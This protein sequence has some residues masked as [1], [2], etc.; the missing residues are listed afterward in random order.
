MENVIVVCSDSLK[1]TPPLTLSSD[2]ATALQSLRHSVLE[3]SIV[4]MTDA[5]GL[6]TF[7]NGNFEKISGYTKQ[8]VL[9]KSHSLL[10]SK[11]HPPKFWSDMWTHI[12]S[13]K[14]WSDEVCNRAKNGSLYWVRSSITPS[15]DQSGKIIGYISIRYDITKEKKLQEDLRQE[16]RLQSIMMQTA[17]VGIF[18]T[19]S[20]GNCLYVNNR[21]AEMTGRPAEESLGA[22]WIA[23]FHAEDK[24]KVFNAWADFVTGQSTF[25]LRWRLSRPDGGIRWVQ[26]T[27]DCVR[28]DEGLVSSYIATAVDI[29]ELINAQH[30]LELKQSETNNINRS[31]ELQTQELERAIKAK[32]TFL[33]NM[34][35]EIRTPLNGVLG[36]SQLLASAELSPANAEIV[37]DIITSGEMLMGIINDLLDFSKIDADKMTLERR[38]FSPRNMVISTA[39]IVKKMVADK[40]I[41]LRI[42]LDPNAPGLVLGDEIR[43]RQILLNLITNAVKFTSKGSV[44]V[45]LKHVESSDN[46][47]SVLL[48]FSITDTGIGLSDEQIGRL[49]KPFSQSDQTITRKF[50]G[51]G[52]GLTIAKRLAKLMGGDIEVTSAL[53]QGSTFTVCIAVESANA[54]LEPKVVAPVKSGLS[55]KN[56]QVLVAEDNATNQKLMKMLCAKF[57]VNHTLAQNG[58]EAFDLAQTKKWDLILMDLQ[59]PEM[60]GLDSTRAIRSTPGPSQNSTIIALTA[61]AF[62][63]DKRECLD[64]GMNGFMGKPLRISELEAALNKAA[65]DADQEHPINSKRTG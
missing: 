48:R 15:L 30:D 31:L 23:S 58:R 20:E 63:E 2:E 34:S 54:A 59:M 28:N 56:L 61:N 42:E 9:G 35:H 46:P 50:G 1:I 64:A 41:A 29:T 39:T 37:Q 21:W 5:R 11:A 16:Q 51:T 4:S 65:L 13:G 24:M 49:F 8:E 6:I 14:I 53:G 47:N 40:G 7:V 26:G 27:A 32:S 38:S 18:R 36:M 44:T 45:G 57:G 52:L 3:T 19:D 60:G 22:A 55:L 25:D 33:A 10:N 17:P 12:A 43:T 62:E